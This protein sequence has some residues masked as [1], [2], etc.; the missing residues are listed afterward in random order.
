MRILQLN[1]LVNDKGH[2]LAGM[3]FLYVWYSMRLVLATYAFLE[4]TCVERTC[5]AKKDMLA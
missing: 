1:E 2:A 4:A 5:L 3:S